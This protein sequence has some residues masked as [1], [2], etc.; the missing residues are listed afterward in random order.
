MMNQSEGGLPSKQKKKKKEEEK[1]EKGEY[2]DDEIEVFT[3]SKS[4]A[5][6]TNITSDD[7]EIRC[8]EAQ[9]QSKQE[10]E[11]YGDDEIAIITT[12]TLKSKSIA[13]FTNVTND[14]DGKTRRDEAQNQLKQKSERMSSSS[15]SKQ[16]KSQLYETL[17]TSSTNV[18]DDGI[19]IRERLAQQWKES[20]IFDV[21]SSSKKN[22]KISTNVTITTS[23]STPTIIN[24][25]DNDNDTR[26]AKRS[27]TSKTTYD[28]TKAKKIIEVKYKENYLRGIRFSPDGTQIMTNAR[29]NTLRLYD[30]NGKEQLQISEPETIYNFQ[31]YP[32]QQSSMPSSCCVLTCSKA[33]PVHLW[34]T[35][36]QYKPFVR[37]TYR[38]DRNG[39]FV[40]PLS[41]RFTP[42]GTQ[43]YTT[44]ERTVRVFDVSRPGNEFEERLTCE[45][46]RSRFGQKGMLSCIAFE[47]YGSCY[48][49]GSFQGSCWIYTMSGQPVCSLRIPSKNRG[50]TQVQFD[51]DG[52]LVFVACR[53]DS[54]VYAFDIRKSRDLLLKLRR[55]N[56]KT[57]NQ[58]IGFD[59]RG[60][61]VISGTGTCPSVCLFDITKSSGSKELSPICTR[62]GFGDVVNDVRFHPNDGSMFGVVTGQRHFCGNDDDD[63]VNENS[64]NRL[65]VFHF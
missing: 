51:N 9:N 14:D 64:R 47:P 17:S 4:T 18:W 28:L 38:A 24:N 62:S 61:Y 37:A 59:V 48:A 10:K 8:D 3:K 60:P 63:D 21:L 34:D 56:T 52:R 46:R 2:G 36:L 23:S 22:S 42:D 29:D 53:R 1:E 40:Y 5:A 49:V 50:V 15:S 43:V 33:Q 44:S 39:E 35:N 55:S 7:V 58:R 16:A 27:R 32:F 25:N 12:T 30:N 20:G 11:E 65:E 54:F 6:F 26:P 41:A 45:T 31:Y 13:T 19:G 57:T